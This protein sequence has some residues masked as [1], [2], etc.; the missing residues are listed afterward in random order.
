[1]LFA[2]PAKNSILSKTLHTLSNWMMLWTGLGILVSAYTLYIET[3]FE[4]NREY[5]AACDI[6]SYISCT[7]VLDSQFATGFG[8]VAPIF[9]EESILNQ[10]N[11]LYGLLVYFTLSILS[12]FASPSLV[13]FNLL[14]VYGIIAGSLY[15]FIILIY[16]RTICLVCYFTYFVNGAL[17]INATRRV[18]TVEQMIQSERNYKKKK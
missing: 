1:H 9:G 17:C 10:K 6:N 5:V 3:K 15:L 18:Y 2:M 8:L 16:L 13:R 11:A 14:V 7:K 4:M 12:R